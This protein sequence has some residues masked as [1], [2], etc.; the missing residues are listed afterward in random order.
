M[1]TVTT[2]LALVGAILVSMPPAHADMPHGNFELRIGSRVDFHTW[3]WA[4]SGCNENPGRCVHV[5]A[6]PQ[7][8][9]NAFAYQADAQ[10]VNG[11]YTFSVDVPDG[12][13][14][15]NIYYG[16]VM[17]THD[18]YTWD[19]TTQSGTLASSAAAGCGGTSPETLSY[20]FALVW[21]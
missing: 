19:P 13:R 6:I 17:P 2:G 14:C 15:G 5:Q 18:V 16:P 3:I 8:V 11:H 10:L 21:M 1:K 20:P 12:L 9:A 4:I 7:P